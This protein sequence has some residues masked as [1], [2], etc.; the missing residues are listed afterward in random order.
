MIE[1]PPLPPGWEYTEPESS[2][3]L[4]ICPCGEVIEQDGSC[5]NGHD[6]PWLEMGLI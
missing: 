5:A 4:L 2:C 3:T 1:L 6:S